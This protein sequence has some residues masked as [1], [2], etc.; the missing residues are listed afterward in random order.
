M[1]LLITVVLIG[2]V[3]F[4]LVAAIDLFMWCKRRK[5][6][7]QRAQRRKARELG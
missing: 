5:G 6:R 2:T 4:L 3:P 7:S 1:Q